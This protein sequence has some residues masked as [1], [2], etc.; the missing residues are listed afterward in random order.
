MVG[1]VE[2]ELKIGLVFR[3]GSMEGGKLKLV[4]DSCNFILNQ[5]SSRDKIG[6]VEYNTVCKE[7]FPLS[8]TSEG[9]KSEASRSQPDASIVRCA[10]LTETIQDGQQDAGRIADEPLRRALSRLRYHPRTTS[11]EIF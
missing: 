11:R 1:V 2:E 6:V 10:K 9:F 4:K 3:S 7:L 5:M 8:R